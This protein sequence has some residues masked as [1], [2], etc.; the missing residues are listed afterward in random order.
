[1]Y[2]RTEFH[3]KRNARVA[4]VPLGKKQE[5]VLLCMSCI[6]GLD[7]YNAESEFGKLMGNY[8]CFAV[9]TD[10]QEDSNGDLVKCE[11]L[12]AI[13]HQSGE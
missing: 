10:Q 4:F 11:A 8:A 2:K 7:A 13:P 1:M 12:F 9:D 5:T 3:C 6:A